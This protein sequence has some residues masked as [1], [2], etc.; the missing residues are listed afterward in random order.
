MSSCKTEIKNKIS[1]NEI[2]STKVNEKPFVTNNLI[3]ASNLSTENNSTIIYSKTIN[4]INKIQFNCQHF[5]N[6]FLKPHTKKMWTHT[7]TNN[8]AEIKVKVL[9]RFNYLKYFPIKIWFS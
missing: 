7:L 3:M 2:T 4:E 9:R 5:A 8:S 6:I 1:N